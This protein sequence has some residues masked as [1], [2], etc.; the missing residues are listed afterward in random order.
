MRKTLKTLFLVFAISV[1]IAVIGMGCDSAG[2]SVKLWAINSTETTTQQTSDIDIDSQKLIV[3]MAKGESEGAQLMIT[4]NRDVKVESVE[5][6]RPK[7]GVSYLPSDSVAVYYE[8]YNTITHHGDSRNPRFKVGDKVSDALL[9][10]KTVIEYGMN[11]I[12]K[13]N[14]QGIY[15]EVTTDSVSVAGVYTSE[16]TIDLSGKKYTFPLEITVWDFDITQSTMK[17]YWMMTARRGQ[18]GSAELD[19]TDK[20]ATEY[21]EAGL[22]YR[23]N[24]ELPFD[25]TGGIERYIG[26]LKQYYNEP[27]FTLYK[28]YYETGFSGIQSAL[29]SDYIYA[30]AKESVK[31]RVNYLDKAM[32]YVSNLVDE[33]KTEE[34]F[35]R[36]SKYC[37]QFRSAKTNA[38]SRLAKE[39]SGTEHAYYF[40]DTV[41]QTIMSIPF[42][43]PICVE[44]SIGAV[45]DRVELTFCLVF[46]LL[47]TESQINAVRG[48]VESHEYE[49]ELWWYS[50]NIPSYP[51]PSNHLD[52][53]NLYFRIM[54]WMQKKNGYDGYLNW[55]AVLNSTTYGTNPYTT[56]A[57]RRDEATGS[58]VDTPGDGFVFYPGEPYEIDGPVGSLRAV[59][60]RDGVEDYEMLTLLEKIYNDK[61][62]DAENILNS[63][64]DQLFSGIVT[65]VTES[66]F[67]KTRDTLGEM[68]DAAS[69]DCGILYKEI[70]VS[71]NN[72]E[73]VFVLADD[74][75]TV[76]Y[77]GQNLI[78]DEYGEYSLSID[79]TKEQYVQLTVSNNDKSVVYNKFIFGK[80]N[81]ISVLTDEKDERLFSK[82]NDSV[83]TLNTDDEFIDGELKSSLKL[84][85]TGKLA[86]SSS[87]YPYF[88]LNLSDISVSELASISLR[89][90]CENDEG[91][92]FTVSSFTGSSYKTIKKIHIEKGWN[93]VNVS[94]LGVDVSYDG[95]IYFR[96]NNLIDETGT[97]VY[98]V[99]L[100][101][102]Y[103]TGYLKEGK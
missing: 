66:E 17:N 77:K 28:L 34:Q 14:T 5:V 71:K 90:Y 18:A 87:F 83:L 1:L 88:A 38:V 96:T 62:Y 6:S 75:A 89:V 45:E 33:P 32:L 8:I 9:P 54:S 97:E 101:F 99:N 85:L 23:M 78:A 24:D 41:K 94:M 102:N 43:M 93:D 100:Y 56:D 48:L 81:V 60:Y 46:P 31:D 67:T 12:E 53:D 29:L 42:I 4:A 84:A 63:L 64:Y 65:T 91:I 47:E 13:G 86:A 68:I 20:M 36:L 35:S 2:N 30:I 3:K 16:I 15:I 58:Y 22:K 98:S 95:K 11:K 82:N 59:S 69:G 70:N 74:A 50:C 19:T 55:C 40:N 37:D 72:G 52:D 51:Y 76:S 39:Y 25:G 92:D 79:L 57:A 80:Y 21:F 26:I 61:G 27:H 103:L 44:N 49:N 7:N 10:F 73:V